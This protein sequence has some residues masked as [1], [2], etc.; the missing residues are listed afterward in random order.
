MM[1]PPNLQIKLRRRVT[2]PFDLLTPKVG[3]FVPLPSGP[4]VPICSK[5]GSFVYKT[6]GSQDW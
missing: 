4:L 2:L 3:G 6:F 5:I 1:P